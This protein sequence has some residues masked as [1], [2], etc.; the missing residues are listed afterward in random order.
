MKIALLTAKPNVG[1]YKFNTSEKRPPN[2]IGILYSILKKDNNDVDI[3]DRYANDLR[4]PEDNFKSYDFVGIYCCSICT[5]D[6]FNCIDKID[7]SN[8]IVGG[9]HA[10]IRPESFPDKV[11]KIVRGEGEN[12]I[13]DIINN[14]ILE[15]IIT[16]KRL[17]NEE[18]DNSL[19]YPYEY[20]W[21]AKRRNRYRWN[22]K[23]HRV[24]PIFTMN[25]SRGC[26]FNCSF[27]DVRN[28]WGRTF[29]Y[30]SSEKVF[31]DITYV[32]SLGAKGIYFREDN[33]T[34]VNK[35]VREV[36]E[37]LLKNN[38]NMKWAC[39]TRVDTVDDELMGLMA[40]SGCIG[41]YVG[42]EHLTQRMLN[43]F[44]KGITVE[45]ILTF[46][47]SANKYKIKTAASLIINHPEET[48]HD[49]NERERLLKIIRPTLIWRNKFR[50]GWK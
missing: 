30:M 27:C 39:E 22:F 41:F 23:F 33:F 31:N 28:V 2:G 9:P 37:S 48:R 38:Y 16:T 15:R 42:V 45:Q 44:N 21:D 49:I 7:C 1:G 50:K 12:V 43:V 32:K 11:T 5:K 46:F 13:L 40:K 8:I 17:S 35:R 24:N 10:Y 47:K 4:W 29:T 3:F 34:V 14:K 26:P 19:R 20:F 36:C 6:I 18:L 25:T